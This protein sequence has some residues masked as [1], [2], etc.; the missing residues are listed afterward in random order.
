MLVILYKKKQLAGLDLWG[1]FWL[2][3][4]NM[5]QLVLPVSWSL[6]YELY[7]YGLFSL[8]FFFSIPVLKRFFPL[9]SLFFVLLSLYLFLHPDL[10]Q[11]FFYS[12]FLLEFFGGVILYIYR[13]KLMH[14]QLLP[15]IFLVATASYTLGIFYETQNGLLRIATFGTGALMIVWLALIIEYRHLW[16]S[17]QIL[18]TLGDTSYT[19]YLSHLI[20]LELFYYSGLRDFF[21]SPHTIV[22]PLLGLLTIL[23]LC[24]IFSLLYYHYIEKP[25]YRAALQ[26]FS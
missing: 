24:I 3:N 9:L 25:V 12:H 15:V 16:S 7:F 18:I 23:F 10:P 14:L 6:S 2:T 20:I 8:T 1:S 13:L 11:R 21:T 26:R 19:L 22:S 4:D 5:F 17:P